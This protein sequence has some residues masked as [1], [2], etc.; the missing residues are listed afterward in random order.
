M[1]VLVWMVTVVME[2]GAMSPQV[3]QGGLV[4]SVTASE[5]EQKPCYVVSCS[6]LRVVL[7]LFRTI[8]S[9]TSTAQQDHVSVA[10]GCTC[11][12]CW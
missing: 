12:C 2:A 5:A 1:K 7:C 8:T 6:E 4:T 10:A 3:R 9:S 11:A